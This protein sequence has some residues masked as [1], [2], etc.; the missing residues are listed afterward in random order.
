MFM[1]AVA[2]LA[3]YLI[4]SIPMGFIIVKVFSGRDIRQVGSGRTGGT[5]AMR[6]AGCGAGLLTGLFDA[7]KGATAVWL[8]KAIV[9]GDWQVWAMTLAGLCAILG[10]NYSVYLKFK[11]GAGAG[12]CV[13]AAMAMW[14]W[15]AA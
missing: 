8:A 14:P 12:P 13:G 7:L 15:S 9:P 10:H 5:N 11:G 6:A 3:A 2:M 1:L 4:G